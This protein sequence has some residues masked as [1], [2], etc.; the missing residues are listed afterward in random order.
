MATIN[1]VA[2]LVRSRASIAN[3]IINT[4]L[5]YNPLK[6]AVDRPL[7]TKDKIMIRS[8]ERTIRALFF[9][10]MKRSPNHAQAPRMQ[11]YLESLNIG[12]VALF[13]E[14]RKRPAPSDAPSQ[15]SPKKQRRE[16][17]QAD[18]YALPPGPVSVAQLFTL[19]KDP[20]T[21][22][23]DVTAIPI[24][25]VAQILVPL[26]QSVNGQK[27]DAAINIV[28][29]RIEALSQRAA[30]SANATAE[31]EDEY[32]PDF[33]M[34][35]AEQ[36][37]NRIQ[38]DSSEDLLMGVPTPE[39][40]STF[41]LPPPEPLGMKELE[42]FARS[43]MDLAF[44]K[45]DIP[46]AQTSTA[47]KKSLGF[48]RFAAAAEDRE[49]MITKFTR[50]LTRP[51]AG[52]PEIEAGSKAQ[53]ISDI[54]RKQLLQYILSNWK[55]RMDVATTWLTEEWYND[56]ICKQAEKSEEST[57]QKPV[58]APNFQKWI[59]RFLDD[60]SAYIGAEDSKLL[61]RFVSEVPSLDKEIIAKIKKLALDP[62]RITMVVNAIQ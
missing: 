60:L 9:N 53:V 56:Q 44:R 54:G 58:Y 61:I 1:A 22:A 50:L 6:L 10:V 36:T 7:T 21:Q 4:I 32:E 19:T 20:G 29:S 34:E 62:E 31:D 5:A 51:T 49:A 38:M 33:A 57:K 46:P 39:V 30:A 8:V 14:S 27:L 25:T 18:S 28:R 23:F 48:V 43:T 17:I 59:H 42:M 55:S 16:E 37:Q 2:G 40:L 47:S 45:I 26:L 15:E 35:D 11:S 52:L 12:R 24:G 41:S 3:K 13:E